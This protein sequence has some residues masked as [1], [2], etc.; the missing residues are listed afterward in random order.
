MHP[1]FAFV[2]IWDDHEYSDDCHGAT[3][4]YFD[5]KRNEEDVPRRR[6]AE[7][8][9]FEYI[10]VDDESLPSGQV[11]LSSKPLYPDSRIYR[12]LRYGKHLHL[13][14]TDSRTFRP[15]HLIPEDAFP[16]TIAVDRAGLTALFGVQGIP[17]DAIF[18]STWT[19]STVSPIS[20]ASC[21][22]YTA[23]RAALR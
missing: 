4:T 7:H 1:R 19:R 13:I 5:G 11:D 23:A 20:S 16:G 10:G 9:F 22:T 15:D 6:N 8:V 17:Y 12:D 18:T 3:A 14:L 2:N 21:S